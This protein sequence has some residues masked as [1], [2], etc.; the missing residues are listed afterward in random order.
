MV[1]AYLQTTAA[2]QLQTITCPSPICWS[3]IS[4]PHSARNARQQHVASGFH[5]VSLSL[6]VFMVVFD[7]MASHFSMMRWHE[8]GLTQHKAD[9]ATV[10]AAKLACKRRLLQQS[11]QSALA[12]SQINAQ[13]QIPIAL[14]QAAP[15]AGSLSQN[16][17][18]G[19]SVLTQ[20]AVGQTAFSQPVVQQTSSLQTSHS[21]DSLTASVLE[22][23]PKSPTASG[24]PQDVD[25]PRAAVNSPGPPVQGTAFDCPRVG[26]TA[27]SDSP[28]TGSPSRAGSKAVPA[29]SFNSPGWATMSPQTSA[30]GT[31]TAATNAGLTGSNPSPASA[32]VQIAG[33]PQALQQRP[34]E[35]ANAST[36]VHQTAVTQPKMSVRFDSQTP[37]SPTQVTAPGSHQHHVP[38]HSLHPGAHAAGENIHTG[39]KPG[40]RPDEQQR[41]RAELEVMH[42]SAVA[43]YQAH[44]SL[45]HASTQFQSLQGFL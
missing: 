33:T 44:H 35:Q 21:T 1:Q 6:Q 17:L 39:Q 26:Q 9:L 41:W 32:A 36:Q 25:S 19:S 22:D 29:R 37:A 24:R 27:N 38:H 18:P 7:I 12:S 43:I 42:R 15:A 34:A 28:R 23:A 16:Q 13:G 2:Y 20:S 3:I 14:G 4:R 45:Q 30:E 31:P 40:V 11:S 5:M 10:Q 8:A